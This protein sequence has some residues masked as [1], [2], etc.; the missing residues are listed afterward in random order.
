MEP[1]DEF[2]D[3]GKKLPYQEPKDFFDQISAKTLERAKQ[4]KRGQQK[5][6]IVWRSVA[7]AASLVAVAFLGLLIHNTEKPAEIVT[8]KEIKPETT[9][10]SGQNQQIKELTI[11]EPVKKAVEKNPVPEMKSTENMNDVLV[12]L[13]DEELMQLAAMY[14]SDLFMEEVMQ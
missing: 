10:I 6:L 4:H 1:K 3:I 7:L 5:R 8:V 11:A 12:D 13:S 2:R 9:I 14:K